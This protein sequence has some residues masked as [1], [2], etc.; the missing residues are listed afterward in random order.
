MR[1]AGTV[2]GRW[3][4]YRSAN[5]LPVTVHVCRCFRHLC[6]NADESGISARGNPEEMQPMEIYVVRPGDSVDS[7][8]QALN[9]NVEQIIYDNQLEYP[10]ELAIGQALL[11][12]G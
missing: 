8:A 6:R 12:S 1:L 2:T 4:P 5:R 10:Y 9:A 11:V 3:T 7:I